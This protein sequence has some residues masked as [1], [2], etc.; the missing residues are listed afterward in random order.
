MTRATQ[1]SVHRWIEEAAGS[2]GG[3]ARERREALLEL[4]STIYEKIED[5]TREGG[6]EDEATQE[7]LESLGDP[8]TMGHAFMPQRPLLP[9]EQTRTFMLWTWALFAVHFVL[10]IGATMAGRE[11]SLPPLRIQPLEH[12]TVIEL[13]A[14]GLEV[15][16]FDAGAMLML[17]MLRTRLG[18]L[19][20]LRRTSSRPS[21]APRRHF[22]SAAFL[23]LVLIVANFLRDN[24]FALYLTDGT[25]TLQVPL[26]GHGFTDNLL[27]FNLWLALAIA[28]EIMYGWRGVGRPTLVLDIVA[29]ATGIFCLLR[30][31]ATRRLVELGTEHGIPTASADTL[32]ALLNTGFS[33]LALV[34]AAM[35]AVELVRRIF[36]LNAL[37]VAALKPH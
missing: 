25:G 28:R 29:R 1:E 13:F 5:R 30:I 9:P 21:N 19:V 22:E 33:L 20:R 10:V 27:L 6:Q 4:E 18:N 24:L 37:R 7:V 26:I 34:T 16:I 36:R 15:L 8:R 31:V 35:I 3:D 17:F 11:L 14:R 2:M 23:G 32:Q 12:Q